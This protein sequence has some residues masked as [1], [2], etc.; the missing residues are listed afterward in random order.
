[1]NDKSTSQDS[2]YRLIVQELLE[3]LSD[4]VHKQLI[5][6]YQVDDPV[7]SM[8]DELGKILME[9]LNRED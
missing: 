2:P 9:I 1:M 7:R 3:E 8:E 4:P 6:A 5:Q